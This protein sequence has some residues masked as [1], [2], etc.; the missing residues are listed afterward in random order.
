MAASLSVGCRPSMSSLSLNST[1][2]VRFEL[3]RKI[4]TSAL[5]RAGRVTVPEKITSSIAEA[6]ID[7]YE[8]SPITQ[9]RASMLSP[10][11]PLKI[12]NYEVEAP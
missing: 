10:V 3:S 11:R 2:A 5:L 12:W 9:R 4:V 8:L 6:R 1:G 7:L